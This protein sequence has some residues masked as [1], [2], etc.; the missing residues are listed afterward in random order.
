[1]SRFEVV[2][3]IDG[4]EVRF[5]DVFEACRH[6]CAGEDYHRARR[7]L[8][9]RGYTKVYSEVSRHARIVP[10]RRANFTPPAKKELTLTEHEE[11][12]RAGTRRGRVS[13]FDNDPL[14]LVVM[15]IPVPEA[16]V[17]PILEHVAAKALTPIEERKPPTPKPPLIE[18]PT[19]KR[20]FGRKGRI[21]VCNGVEYAN[22]NAAF[23]ANGL[24]G[25]PWTGRCTAFRSRILHPQGYGTF[26]HKEAPGIVLEF[27]VIY[28]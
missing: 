20:V 22:A 25:N 16:N 11:M 9:Q 7:E 2:A 27:K 6:L 19:P 15:A 13:P 23:V 1:M 5:P 17:T 24:Y 10:I 21:I 3:E 18:P 26:T 28:R 12:K 8:N 14:E 4:A